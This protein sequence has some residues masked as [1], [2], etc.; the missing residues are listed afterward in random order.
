MKKERFSYGPHHAGFEYS[1]LN[2]NQKIYDNNSHLSPF[3]SLFRKFSMQDLCTWAN[4]IKAM[5][6][7]TIFSVKIKICLLFRKRT[8]SITGKSKDIAMDSS[9]HTIDLDSLGTGQKRNFIKM[10]AKVI[11]SPLALVLMFKR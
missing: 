3:P 10:G 2:K 7:Q 1:V 5:K 11:K 8:K 9:E 6:E 4:E